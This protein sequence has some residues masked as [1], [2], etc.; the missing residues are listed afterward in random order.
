MT[1]ENPEP[2][3]VTHYGV[4]THWGADGIWN[5]GTQ[6]AASGNKAFVT[7]DLLHQLKFATRNLIAYFF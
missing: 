3:V 6:S 1:W 5:F 4:R 7:F 2:F